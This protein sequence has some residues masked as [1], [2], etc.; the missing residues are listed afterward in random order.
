M[1]TLF[2]LYLVIFILGV[3][4]GWLANPYDESRVLQIFMT[5]V[6]G[7][8]YLFRKESKKSEINRIN[9]IIL[10]FILS[11]LFL[12]TNNWFKT[13]DLIQWLNLGLLFFILIKSD[14]DSRISTNSFVVFIIFSLFAHFFIPLAFYDFL[15]KGYLY[16]WQMNSSSVR[17]LN[18]VVIP[19]FWLSLFFKEKNK[20]INILYPVICYFFGLGLLVDGARSA[21]LSL[22]LPLFILFILNH[23]YRRDVLNTFIWLALAFFTYQMV[24]YFYNLT[25]EA[26][27]SLN[28]AR[29]S[30]SYRSEMWT[31]MFE[32]WKVKPFLGTGGGYLAQIQ[33]QYGH[34]I[35]NA[36]LR[37]VFEWGILGFIFLMWLVHHFIRLMKSN[38]NVVLK[39]GVLA[40]AIDAMF[41]GNFIYPVSQVI[42]VLFISLAFSQ[43]EKKGYIESKYAINQKYF[44]LPIFVIY[45]VLVITY[46][47]SDLMCIGCTSNEGRA[48]PF[49]WEHGGSTKLEH[50][51]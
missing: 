24:Y 26:E 48:A 21:I 9:L 28:I 14:L 27:R 41:S 45:V 7:S 3:H 50:I 37:L 32:Q 35:H 22:I 31:F 1:N 18:S 43:M 2:F 6:L 47:G 23:G 13:V 39:M 38:V 4:F 8:L 42:C 19:I 46:L 5:V 15:V 16:S 12:T 51:E 44:F 30:S 25:H 40:I 11:A 29:Y 33:Y 17:I 36:Y 34:H 20:Y 49:F 10:F